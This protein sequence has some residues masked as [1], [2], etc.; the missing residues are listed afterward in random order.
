MFGSTART[1]RYGGAP[2][3]SANPM[4]RRE[5]LGT[6]CA[7]VFRPVIA[8]EKFLREDTDLILDD[9]DR[10]LM[11]ELGDEMIKRVRDLRAGQAEPTDAADAASTRR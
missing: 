1:G 3:F 10:L 9:A 6:A 11:A 7:L 5:P 4:L 2:Y 8:V